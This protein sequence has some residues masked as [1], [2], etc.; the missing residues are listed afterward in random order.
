MSSVILERPMFPNTV[1][2][3]ILSTWRSC[4]QKAFLQYVEHWKPIAQSVHLVAGG[5]FASGIEAARNVFYVEG[6]SPQDAEAGG[7]TALIKHYGD[8]ECPADSA[9][10]LERMCGALEFYFNAYPLGAD[11]ANPITLASGRRGI[12]FSF[13]EPLPV[14]H[15]VTGDPILYTGR[16]D[17]IAERA[18]GVYVYDEKTTSALGGSWARQWEMRGQ[19]TGYMWAAREQGIKTAGAIVRGVSILKTKYD[20]LEVPTYRSDYEINL[21]HRQTVRDVEAMIQCWREGY[22]DYALDGGCTEYG[23]CSFTRVCKS[24]EPESWLPVYFERRVWDPLLRK[25]VTVQEFEASWGH[26]RAVPLPDETSNL[27]SAPASD[28]ALQDSFRDLLKGT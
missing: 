28:A 11:G 9:K 1:D 6:G 25:E 23:G 21:W 5:A 20:T 15:P 14:L 17:M 4:R 24:A 3:T 8:F 12:E 26:V 7:L 10:S 2:S 18:G 13:A 27:F 16:S 22:W 19:F